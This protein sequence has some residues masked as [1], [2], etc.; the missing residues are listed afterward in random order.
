MASLLS[1]GRRRSLRILLPLGFDEN[2]D[3]IQMGISRK[4]WA[5]K[6]SN[7]R[8]HSRQIYSLLHLTA[9][10]PALNFKSEL[11]VR[12]ELTTDGLQNRCSTS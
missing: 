8:R 12:I 3:S 1:T 5:G 11:E 2:F 6:D 4:Q 9:L 10:V 7:L